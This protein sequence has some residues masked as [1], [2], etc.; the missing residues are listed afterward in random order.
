MSALSELVSLCEAR[1]IPL[2]IFFFRWGKQSGQPLY[3][4][5][6]RHAANHPVRDVRPWFPKRDPHALMNS[7][8]DTHP[9]AAAHRI[10]AEH[11]AEEIAAAL[12]RPA[13]RE[14]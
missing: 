3:E 8:I 10:M 7:R 5:V 4:D 2:V 14:P 13:A 12:D 11:M 1:R 9:N 6:V